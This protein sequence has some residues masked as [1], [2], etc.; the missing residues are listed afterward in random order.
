MN[1]DMFVPYIFVKILN[2][3][4]YFTH[5]HF[6]NISILNFFK[7]TPPP[8][9]ER[10]NFKPEAALSICLASLFLHPLPIWIPHGL[11]TLCNKP[12][13]AH[14]L[15][16]TLWGQGLCRQ[17]RGGRR[18]STCP[19]LEE[20]SVRRVTAD[21]RRRSHNFD[22]CVGGGGSIYAHTHGIK[23]TMEFFWGNIC[24]VVTLIIGKNPNFSSLY[25]FF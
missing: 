12:R 6:F 9:N 1:I 15:R 3:K 19:Y 11:F 5:I 7:N 25:F 23:T 13:L 22:K 24:L 4:K 17:V 2:E 14:A 18:R 10:K 20:G 16:Q 8:E 21:S